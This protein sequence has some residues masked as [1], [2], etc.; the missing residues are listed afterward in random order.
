[1]KPMVIIAIIIGM[2][3]IGFF[4]IQEINKQAHVENIKLEYQKCNEALSSLG[5][6]EEMEQFSLCIAKLNIELEHFLDKQIT[7]P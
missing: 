5:D 4:V 1:M 7:I 2:G 3:I 6:V